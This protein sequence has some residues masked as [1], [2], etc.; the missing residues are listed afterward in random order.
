MK[1][2]ICNDG[3]HAHYYQR[4]AWANAFKACGAQVAL[5]EKDAVPAFDV[6]DDFEPDIFMGQSYNLDEA[7]IKCI[8][9]RPHLKVGLR[10]GDWGDHAAIVDKEKYNILFCSPKERE[11]LQRLKDETGQP[12]FVHIHYTS[13]AVEWTHNY[14]ETIGIRPISLMMCADVTTYRDAKFDP[15]LEC[16]IGFVG[17]YWP[18]KGQVINKYLFPL[19]GPTSQTMGDYKVKIFG[20]Q[21]WPV[22]QYCGFIQDNDVKNLFRS[23]AICPNLSEPHAQEFGFD[24]NERIFKILY[25]GGFCISDNVEGYKSLFGDSVP[26]ANDP[27]H[28]KLLIDQYLDDPEGRKKLSE[29]GLKI[30][31]RNHTS[32]HRAAQILAEFGYEEDSKS[33]IQSY[34]GSYA[35]Y[36]G[37]IL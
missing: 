10:A 18:Y 32:V 34:F 17:G 1:I 21:P 26:L 27:E 14:F 33:I 3:R 31:E 6:F 11:I 19:L 24:V 20:N 22:N 12:E 23:A 8:M 30:V 13:E 4:M 29:E 25:A 9:E 28:F 2:L 16:D 37:E 15:A 7:T 36:K 35:F 5:W